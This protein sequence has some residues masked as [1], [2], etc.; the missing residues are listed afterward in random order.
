MNNINGDHKSNQHI[1]RNLLVYSRV[2]LQIGLGGLGCWYFCWGPLGLSEAGAIIIGL[3]FSLCVGVLGIRKQRNLADPNPSASRGWRPSSISLQAALL[4]LFSL[5]TV[6]Q[7][8]RTGVL[9]HPFES[10]KENF[11]RLTEAIELQHPYLEE[12]SLDLDK[13]NQSYSPLVEAA[14]SDDEYHQ[15]VAHFLSEMGDAHTGLIQPWVGSDRH[16]FG[17]GRILAD[18]L[19]VDLVGETARNAGILPGAQLLMVD[20]LPIEQALAALP[21]PLRVGSTSWQARDRASFHLLSTT[22]SAL[23]VS[24]QNP[25]TKPETKILIWPA[26]ERSETAAGRADPE[27]P[28]IIGEVLPSGILQITIPTFSRRTGHNLVAEFD[29]LLDDNLDAPGI[30]LDLRG[31]GGGDSRIAN[32]IAG[33][34]FE[35]S[36][37]YG[38]DR[39]RFR[40]PLHAWRELWNYCVRPRGSIYNGPV[41]LLI[42]TAN[43]SSAEQFIAALTGSGRSISV[44]RPTAGSSGNPITFR[45]TGGGK[46]RFS[47]AAFYLTDG[48]MLEGTGFT[49][50]IPVEFTVLDFL[51]NRDPD[52]A[53]AVSILCPSSDCDSQTH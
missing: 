16:Y 10:R 19:I 38:Q 17:T 28:L 32:Q 12:K 6:I 14:A 42:D 9:P 47:T 21:L 44:G 26:E 46:A 3:S 40:S 22:G 49:P 39:F 52:L 29:Q 50:D 31:N 30:I 33:R 18:G 25:G 53:A 7:L 4:L 37:C 45:L 41:L 24:F 20:G 51:E 1:P 34:F 5:F 43:M 11:A 2:I 48:T 36:F 23:E 13:L 35:E 15:L 27:I 8:D